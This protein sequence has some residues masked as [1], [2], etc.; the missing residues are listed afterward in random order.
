MKILK[1]RRGETITEALVTILIVAIAAA[2]FATMVMVASNILRT[3]TEETAKMYGELSIAETRTGG[4][5][6]TVKFT[7]GIETKTPAVQFY[8]EGEGA[9]TSYAKAVGG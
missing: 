7:I 8:S 6:G 9:L 1:G 2:M 5:E 4:T 3:A